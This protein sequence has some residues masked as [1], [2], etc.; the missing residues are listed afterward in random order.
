MLHARWLPKWTRLLNRFCTRSFPFPT[1]C[2]L[3]P[4]NFPSLASLSSQDARALFAQILFDPIFNAVAQEKRSRV[5]RS[6]CLTDEE[7][8]VVMQRL[9]YPTETVLSNKI[10]RNRIVLSFKDSPRKPL[11]RR[12]SLGW[13]SRF[14]SQVK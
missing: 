5:G 8:S 14:E 6:V 2:A 4:V 7:A 9:S 1:H 10:D 11:G 13:D 12:P 3:C